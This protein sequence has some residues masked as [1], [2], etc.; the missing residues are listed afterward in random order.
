MK[1]YHIPLKVYNKDIWIPFPKLFICDFSLLCTP[2]STRAPE[3][4]PVSSSSSVWLV[5]VSYD[6]R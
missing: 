6:T 1:L 5:V 2:V 4:Q 3:Q